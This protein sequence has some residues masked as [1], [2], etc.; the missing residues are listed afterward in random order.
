M[1]SKWYISR[2]AKQEDPDGPELTAAE[3]VGPVSA[4]TVM[5]MASLGWLSQD[6]LVLPEGADVHITVGQF[7]DMAREGSLPGSAETAPVAAPPALPTPPSDNALPNWLADVRQLEATPTPAIPDAL[8]WLRDIR[9]IEES[10]RRCSVPPEIPL[11][12]PV[13]G[14]AAPATAPIAPPADQREQRGYDAETGQI[15]DAIAYARWQKSEA[16]HR[17]AGQEQGSP[18]VAEVFLQAQRAIQEWVDADANK[19]LVLSGNRYDIRHC[20]TACA[21]MRQFD[22]Y[23][24]VMQ[25]KLWTRL[26]FLVDNRRKY[27]QATR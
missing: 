23:G 15:L 5:E 11:A 2:T 19:D 18:S 12:T 13:A 10:L 24:P 27:Y 9:Q 6:D 8:T 26:F 3:T 17:Q 22:A 1:N 20:P 4:T 25:G 21:L 16:E 14:A 7:L